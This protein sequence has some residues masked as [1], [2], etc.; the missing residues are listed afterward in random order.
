MRE[1]RVLLERLL[2]KQRIDFTSVNYFNRLKLFLLLLVITAMGSTALILSILGVTYFTLLL[3]V[4]I[5]LFTIGAVCYLRSK[6]KSTSVKGDAL[7]LNS[8]NRT[9]CVTS[10][11]SV[12]RVKTKSF[13]GLQWT[14]VNFKL[15]GVS[16]S[17]LFFTIASS[18]PVRPEIS[19]Q[20]AIRLSKKQNG[21][22]GLGDVIVG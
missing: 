16:R 18:V 1:K 3:S 6:V 10:I 17:A 13:F 21:K 12:K 19:L 8:I 22:Y 15:D 2:S 5:S 20:K 9:S 7:I 4:G 11:L 14:N